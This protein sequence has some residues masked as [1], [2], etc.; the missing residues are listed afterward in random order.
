MIRC[1]L[2][3]ASLMK[4]FKLNHLPPLILHESLP[5]DLYE[6]NDLFVCD[7]RFGMLLYF[8]TTVLLSCFLATYWVWHPVIVAVQ[9]IDCKNILHH[10]TACWKKKSCDQLSLEA[11]FL[12]VLQFTRFYNCSQ[13]FLKK[14]QYLASRRRIRRNASH[15]SVNIPFPLYGLICPKNTCVQISNAIIILT[16][17][18]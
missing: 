9:L 1:P 10:P 18:K 8:T 14:R 4:I 16:Y 11:C 7:C 3:A 5:S 2:T 12:S 15:T 17:R 13:F 6:P